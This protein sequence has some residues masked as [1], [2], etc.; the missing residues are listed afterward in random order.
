[1]SEQSKALWR[2]VAA[3]FVLEAHHYT[4]L[5]LACESL[6]RAEEARKILAADGIVVKGT[7]EEAT[8]VKAHP[9]V[10][11]ERDS[12]LRAARLLREIGLDET[13]GPAGGPRLPPIAGEGR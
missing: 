4:L 7:D 2:R 3:D 9:A 11:V 10:A 13:G 5:R 8:V 12:Q 1:L 6:D